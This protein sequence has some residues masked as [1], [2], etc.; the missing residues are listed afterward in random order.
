MR[1]LFESLVPLFA[2][3]VYA[4]SAVYLK[5]ATQE[6][7][8]L[9][10]I[11]FLT[12][13]GQALALFPL[14]AL[15]T[16]P[17]AWRDAWE[18]GWTALVFALGQALVFVGL[19]F[20]DVSVVTPVLG[21]KVL[22]VALGVGWMADEQIPGVWWIAAA[23]SAGAALLMGIGVPSDRRRLVIGVLTGLGA[24]AAFSAVDVFFQA[25]AGHLGVWPFSAWVALGMGL[26]SL[27]L[28]PLLE[29]PLWRIPRPA[30][31]AFLP[32]LAATLGQ[33]VLMAYAVVLLKG[34]AWANLLYSSRGLWSIVLVWVW[35]NAL[36]NAEL[37]G[38]GPVLLR[39]L[40]GALL[41]LAAVVLVL[42]KQ[43]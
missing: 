28:L 9:W 29:G 25:W 11:N 22:M 16:E 31:R 2:G 4:I 1:T 23:L 7:G 18:V 15:G 6:G 36:G 20:G 38:G 43:D 34:A 19:R 3:L 37:R 41:M 13:W 42:Y 5:R 39:R 10:R 14:A 27:S 17:L 33:I 35:G 32:G 8:G 26:L 12:N 40:G 24:A 21:V 30:L